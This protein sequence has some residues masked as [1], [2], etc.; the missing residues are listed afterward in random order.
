MLSDEVLHGLIHLRLKRDAL[1]A[2]VRTL[3][4]AGQAK[5][6]GTICR[7]EPEILLRTVIFLSHVRSLASN[8]RL[9]WLLYLVELLCLLSQRR[10]PRCL[11]VQLCN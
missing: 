8:S 7:A 3:F 11:K 9:L 5:E 10:N 1:Y 6:L 2:S 4:Q